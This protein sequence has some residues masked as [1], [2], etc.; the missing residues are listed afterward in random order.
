[1]IDF[2]TGEI[3]TNFAR[4]SKRRVTKMMIIMTMTLI[5]RLRGRLT[6]RKFFPSRINDDR[7]KVKKNLKVL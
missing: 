3:D 5:R 6:R 7:F 2:A 1:M 4:E